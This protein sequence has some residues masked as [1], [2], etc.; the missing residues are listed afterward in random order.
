MV[1]SIIVVTPAHRCNPPLAIAA[2]RAGQYGLLDL[3]WN[4]ADATRRAALERL[5]RF[6]GQTDRWG[7]RWDMLELPQ[8]SPA[9]LRELASEPWPLLLLAGVNLCDVPAESIVAEARQIARR[10]LVEAYSPEQAMAAEQAG[11]DGVVLV[12]HEAGG[13]VG[14]LSAFVFLQE[15]RGK[16]S[17][18]YWIR[19]GLG[20]QTA[21]AAKVAG[22]SGVVL[23]EQLWLTE[24]SPL[25][26]AEREQWAR[27]GGSD[28]VCLG[29]ARTSYRFSGR[30]GRAA[31]DSLEKQLATGKPAAE[32]LRTQLL[33]DSALVAE[34]SHEALL[35]LGQEIGFAA[36]LARRYRTV[37]GVLRGF[38]Q[39]ADE[40]LVQARTQQALAP[41][42]PLAEALGTTYPILQGPMTRVS[43][44]APFCETVAAN[45]ALPFLALS[46]L[47]QTAVRELLTETAKRLGDRPWG[48][49]ILGFVP[50]TLRREQLD[51]LQQIRP[52]FAIIA[53]GRPSQAKELEGLGIATY[54][55]VPSPGLFR[56][57]LGEGVRKF[58][59]EGRE[60]GGHVGPRTSFTL[61]QS[62]VDVLLDAEMSDPENVHVVFAGGIHDAI[63]AAMVATIAAPLVARGIKIG[64]LMGT[65]Y[66]F[67]PEAVDS[68]AITARYQQQAIACRE[69][70]LLVSGVGHATRGACTPFVDDFNAKKRQLILAGEKPDEVKYELE[71]LNVGRLR[72]AAKGLTRRTVGGAADE[73]IPVDEQQQ[74]RQGMYMIGDVARL[75]DGVV[76]MRQLHEEV[77]RGSVALLGALPEPEP[78]KK[79]DV[80][81][82][83]AAEPLAVVGLGCLFPDSPDVQRY[84]QN[85]VAGFD[86]IREVPE[87]RWRV[88]D[89]YDADRRKPDRVYAK[90]GSFLGAVVF[91]PL[92]Y[93]MPPASLRAIE[94]IQLMALEVARQAL[95]DA[96][97]ERDSF[98]RERT[99]VI[100]G[101]AGSHDQGMKYSV[102]TLLRHWLPKVEGLD[103]RTRQHILAD[104]ESQLPEWTEDSFAGFLLN[105]VA[106]RI[107]NRFDLTGSN[108]TVDAACASSLAALH[109]AAEQLRS[110]TCDAALVGA[111]DGTNNPFCFMSFAKTHAMSPGGRSRP[112][113]ETADG[114]GLGEGIAAVVLKRLSDAQREGD[115]IY[116]VIR[117]IGSSSDGRNRSM[118][119]PYPDGQLR[120]LTRAY[121]DADLP[122]TTVSLVESHSTGTS[123]G[124]QV[125]I[126]ALAQLF[127][128]YGAAPRSCAI[129][130]VKSMI[131]HAKAAAGVASLVKTVL[132][133]DHKI[134]P[135]TIHVETPNKQ[136]RTDDCPFY[137]SAEPRPW[138]DGNSRH[139]RRAGVSAFGFGGTNFHVVLE[140]YQGEYLAGRQVD[141]N[142]RAGEMCRFEAESQEA[143]LDALAAF[144]KQL[145][146]APT[147]NLAQVAYCVHREQEKRRDRQ[148]A[149]R[150]AIVATSIADLR[151]KIAL[152]RKELPGKQQF[153]TPTGIYYDESKPV[154]SREICFLFPGQGSQ[155]VNMLKDLLMLSPWAYELYA[156]ADHLLEDFFDEPLSRSI[157]PIP[158]FSDAERKQQQE[159]LNDT[160]LAQPALGLTELFAAK[161][162]GRFGVQPGMV[163]GHS[164]GEYVAL[165]AAGVHGPDALLR[166]SALRGQAV[167]EAGKSSAGTMAAVHGNAEETAAALKELALDVRLAN[168]NADVQTIIAG[169]IDQIEKAVVG[170]KEK[171]L[172]AKRIAV[173]AAFHTPWVE[174]AKN[175]MLGHLA[176]V[177]M[178]APKIPVYSNATAAPY[179]SEE[180]GIRHLL[181]EHLVNPVRFT[182]QVEAMYRDG[183]R[184]F[185]EVGPG[186]VLT[187]LV[188][189][190]LEGREHVTLSLESGGR[191]GS[192]QLAHV[193]ARLAVLGLPVRLDSWF[194]HRPLADWSLEAFLADERKKS[195]GKPTDWYISPGGAWPVSA[196]RSPPRRVKPI[197][198]AKRQPSASKPSPAKPSQ[199]AVPSNGESHSASNGDGAPSVAG[200]KA[201]PKPPPEPQPQA[202]PVRPAGPSRPGPAPTSST[203][204]TTATLPRV[205]KR[206]SSTT[207]SDTTLT[208]L[209]S[210]ERQHY[211]NQ[212]PGNAAAGNSAD[213]M[214]HFQG[215]MHQWL[216]LQQQQQQVNQQFLQMQQAVMLACLQGGG[217]SAPPKA[218]PPAA[219]RAVP[220][221]PMPVAPSPVVP[222]PVVPSPLSGNGS[223]TP[224]A[225]PAAPTPAAKPAAKASP[226]SQPVAAADPAMA[227]AAAFESAAEPPVQQTPKASSAESAA[228][229]AA[230]SAA[231]APTKAPPAN[232]EPPVVAETPSATLPMPA[233]GI[234]SNGAPPV[235]KFRE[236]L[237]QAISDRTGYPSEML[238]D[239]LELE[240]ELGIDS[241]KTVEIFSEL[242]DYHAWLPGANEEEDGGLAT[243][244][245][246]TTIRAI[247]NTY[248]A[249]AN[250]AGG[251]GEAK[252]SGAPSSSSATG[253]EAD[254]AVE[255]AVLQAVEAPRP[256]ASGDQKKKSSLGVT[257]S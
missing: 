112:F 32:T 96:H 129:G 201:Q 198:E 62:A 58:V 41:Q 245:E 188:R 36:T 215:A 10:V 77:C 5:V 123:I 116:A 111:A 45:G 28:T 176:D 196:G 103:E 163:G 160:R 185:I 158:V 89:F 183:A 29:D 182:E 148:K 239:D 250:G 165:C 69:T 190:N 30:Q 253:S 162:L 192:L 35:P 52:N 74:H 49:G 119:A 46:L 64:L 238:G 131:G 191:P 175:V 174:G 38:A 257:S 128:N 75:R 204:L 184:V 170:L 151:Q 211:P 205:A 251:N 56:S 79:P 125:E 105:V 23:G 2:S 85:I 142:A 51:V 8:R 13:R 255:R 39:A 82:R 173:T 150:L 214:A 146:P 177:P 236:D 230:H 87:D 9:Y 224:A 195:Q 240:A 159:R 114:I 167:H 181:G 228:P 134:L 83:R 59:F 193:L 53:G 78:S 24:E 137:V 171:G 199:L 207:R 63:S 118:T 34:S 42:S 179:P 120:A 168:L 106:G 141:L 219:A 40:A 229:A 143:V 180:A 31:L 67:T 153:E 43:D 203:S 187:G 71:M 124:D 108:Y 154:E 147:E 235:E 60:C 50:A 144:E 194:E 117:G 256:A 200:P 37:A 110:G 16:L 57:F 17:L 19:G 225:R 216:Q 33:A 115:K 133:L 149:A 66:L 220:S 136:L 164:Y 7:V 244:A 48:V 26:Q 20:P 6:A 76:S 197:A 94:P 155:R 70:A 139:P 186:S 92:R 223:T 209:T 169:P 189:R 3:G 212:V 226:A 72:I 22:A 138:L 161:L 213:L 252:T 93:R 152:T 98:P 145:T 121:E 221:G 107:A 234:G 18:P 61:W 104:L 113:D 233:G 237:I 95:E 97:Y 88:D 55:H 68:G 156:R 243:F 1:P 15:V 222:S 140:E 65:A 25:S 90:W 84:W 27:L 12:G 73:L 21:A 231:R 4:V 44:V 202:A 232:G 178:H 246:M 102:R 157:M 248:A 249:N 132:A 109:A 86:A 101:A 130:S 14:A 47:R 91:D 166:L 80:I 241:I 122:P 218:A 11:A 99:A 247:V 227:P 206:P 208:E 54:V 81:R 217:P 254:P 210:M 242:T 172:R 135:P 126:Q 100:F 127:H